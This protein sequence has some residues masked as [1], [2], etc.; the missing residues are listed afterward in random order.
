MQEEGFPGCVAFVDGTTIPLSQNPPIDGNHYFDFVRR[1]AF[2]FLYLH[3]IDRPLMFSCFSQ[4][5]LHFTH[6][7]LQCKQEVHIVPC[8]LSWI[9][10]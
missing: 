7:S 5:I 4:Q 9:M 10:P 8:R 1:G 2:S 6:S 3:F